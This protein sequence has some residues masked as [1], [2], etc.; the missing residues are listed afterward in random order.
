[1]PQFNM[2]ITK[3]CRDKNKSLPIHMVIFLHFAFVNIHEHISALSF[4]MSF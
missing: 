4:T 2:P 1:M 3:M